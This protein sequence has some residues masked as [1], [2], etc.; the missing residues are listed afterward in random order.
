MYNK[1]REWSFN[2]SIRPEVSYFVL[3]GWE[4]SFGATIT[5]LLERG[6]TT[7]PQLSPPSNV[8]WGVKV[9]TAYYYPLS[10]S[11][12]PYIGLD[13]G[14]LMAN[15]EY[16]Q[17]VWYLRMPIGVA[18]FVNPNVALTFGTNLSVDFSSTAIFEN[19]TIDPGFL[20]V[21]ILFD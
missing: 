17:L 16:K 5:N 15:W 13:L 12:Q 7:T 6:F 10:S 1:F 14:T 18:W 8:Y 21:K 9:G 20:G 2:Y 3:D 11:F 4:I 19:F